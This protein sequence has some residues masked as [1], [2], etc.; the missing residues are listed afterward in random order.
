MNKVADQ[1]KVQLQV[2]YGRVH[3]GSLYLFQTVRS[4]PGYVCVIRF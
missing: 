3:L 1:E 2:Q 4:N